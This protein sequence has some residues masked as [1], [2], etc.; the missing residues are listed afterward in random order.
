MSVYGTASCKL[1]IFHNYVKIRLGIAQPRDKDVRKVG[2]RAKHE[3]TT[4][5]TKS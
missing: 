4:S 2:F 1:P 3:A 5:E